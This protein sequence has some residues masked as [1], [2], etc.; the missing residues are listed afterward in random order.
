MGD[1]SR[2]GRDPAGRWRNELG[3]EMVLETRSD[4]HL[5]GTYRSPVGD[6]SGEYALEG[7]FDPAPPEGTEGA[8]GWSVL[9]RNRDRDAH[10]VT[11][12]CGCHDPA[13]DE[14]RTTWLLTAEVSECA[15]WSSTRV[16]HDVFVRVDDP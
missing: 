14:L 9:W 16:G 8:L 7:R 2:D 10:S 1:G 12:W 6:A 15:A 13:R 3:A 5:G 11:S 4:G